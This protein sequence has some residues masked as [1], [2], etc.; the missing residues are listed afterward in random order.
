LDNLIFKNTDIMSKNW[1]VFIFSYTVYFIK[2][3][4]N[5]KIMNK[6]TVFSRIQAIN[7]IFYLQ[8]K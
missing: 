3:S 2:D 8:E 6:D 4:Y 1:K 5:E 7:A